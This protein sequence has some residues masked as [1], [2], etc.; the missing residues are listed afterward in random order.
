MTIAESGDAT[1]R[2]GKAGWLFGGMVVAFSA[3][4]LVGLSDGWAA[5]IPSLLILSLLTSILAALGVR[6][7]LRTLTYSQRRL[8]S[9]METT[10]HGALLVDDAG[11]IVSANS[12]AEVML[13]FSDGG[14]CGVKVV[15]VVPGEDWPGFLAPQETT[16]V[17]GNP[18]PMRAVGRRRDGSELPIS[19]LLLPWVGDQR[20]CALFLEDKSSE[21]ETETI[22]ETLADWA[23]V[24]MNTMSEGV[25]ILDHEASVVFANSS[26]AKCLAAT[27][28][29]L[30]GCSFRDLVEEREVGDAFVDAV[31]SARAL[32]L[33]TKMV[34]TDGSQF[35]AEIRLTPAPETI[36]GIGCVVAVKDVSEGA[37]LRSKL[38]DVAS[39][40]YASVSN[41][42][43]KSVVDEY[44]RAIDS[45]AAFLAKPLDDSGERVTVIAYSST[46]SY[47]PDAGTELSGS[48]LTRVMESG[49]YLHESSVQKDF[50]LD[51]FLADANAQGFSGRLFRDK[52][53][54]PV[55]MLIG[56]FER[57][58]PEE[59]VARSIT[60][61]FA[62]RA[63]TALEG[64]ATDE[65]VRLQASALAASDNEIFI[66]DLTGEILW[67]NPALEK[68]SGYSSAELIGV[69][70]RV[71]ESEH[72][73]EEFYREMKKQILS[74]ESWFGEIVNRRKDGS[75]YIA[76]QTITPVLGDE[77]GKPRH[78]VAIRR[79]VTARKEAERKIAQSEA[80]FRDLFENSPYGMYRSTEAG[81]F[82]DVNR[83][84][85]TMLGYSSAEEVLE[86][87]M[88]D[89]LYLDTHE[90]EVLLEEGPAGEGEGIVWRRKDG[91]K[92]YFV[93]RG[94]KVLNPDGSVKWFEMVVEDVSEKR[95]LAAQ[96]RQAQK[97][98]A[99]GQLTAGVAHDFNNLL[100]VVRGNLQLASES[101]PGSKEFHD[102]LS[103]VEY[104]TRKATELVTRLLGFSR[105][106]ELSQ[107]A[108]S[109]AALVN[110]MMP[111]LQSS[112]K[113][114]ITLEVVAPETKDLV[115]VDAGA[116]EQIIMNLVTNAVAAMPRGGT[117]RV[118][119]G[120]TTIEP[121][122]DD[123]P[124]MSPGEYGTIVVID[125]GTGIP[126][127][128]KDR[129]FEPFFTTK[130]QGV[131]TGLGLSMVY[132]LMK[133]Q[134]GSVTIDS[135]PGTGTTVTLLLPISYGARSHEAASRHEHKGAPVGGKETI[136][137]VED[138]LELRELGCRILRRYGYEVI[139]AGDGKEA[140]DI[141][142]K[143]DG[144]VDLVFSDF[145][146]P[147][148]G[149]G[150]LFEALSKRE[151]P[152]HFILSSGYRDHQ[153]INEGD[154][155]ESV[156]RVNK[157][158]E[159]SELL[160]AVRRVLD[161]VDEN[162]PSETTR[163]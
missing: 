118:E 20:I 103:D 24:V 36:V 71:F 110:G 33:E 127:N 140:L 35:A 6:T 107:T 5:R 7:L 84:L 68:T 113:E 65:R 144:K 123:L 151:N 145:V 130:A 105:Q 64:L 89:D 148:M 161:P 93:L 57:R 77:D 29:G 85:V 134:G 83:A 78:F 115:S 158:W 153:D 21:V 146:M 2:S 17:P 10:I 19:A 52:H 42:S 49:S 34:R 79:D 98:E 162:E 157:P 114:T 16:E 70:Q 136:L 30:M 120:K 40:L 142:S 143:V 94:R 38:A 129:I 74:G 58:M 87:N 101:E 13:G 122:E 53:G 119:V 12:S 163:V 26:V 154:A 1:T 48:I 43:L 81:R 155:L 159:I 18:E 149:G 91:S 27:V 55:C 160:H 95:T 116:L 137:L 23:T 67:V 131:G 88:G 54:I 60:D 135:E 69:N 32:N 63:G 8:Y 96:L 138:Q 46:G 126:S 50:S 15:D 90:R 28:T 31:T 62:V 80:D 121:G 59:F 97:M 75:T 133:Q 47:V 56:L 100:T 150:E 66:T 128:I 4:V 106:A 51:P 41:Q 9:V 117:L 44:R 99:V 37:D 82:V 14:L 109:L 152:P 3:V 92:G 141:I 139:E 156:V 112:A 25:L 39:G 104:A 61:V 76:E 11:T 73:D 86:L 72:H 132:G 102:R 45:D 22:V 124:W 125:T 111:V 147:R 108:T